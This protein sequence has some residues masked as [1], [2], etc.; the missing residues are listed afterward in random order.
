[1][2]R[3]CPS[4]MLWKTSRKKHTT[5]PSTVL[6]KTS[7]PSLGRSPDP[8]TLPS[9]T[10][11]LPS[12]LWLFFYRQWIWSA[13]KHRL[14]WTSCFSPRYAPLNLKSD[15]FGLPIRAYQGS[16][17]FDYYH[18]EVFERWKPLLS[19]SQTLEVFCSTVRSCW[20]YKKRI[21]VS[22]QLRP[23]T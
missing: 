18:W 23:K 17:L 5:S 1:M 21:R 8:R 6:D 14:D 22:Q 10:E 4:C 9:S 19:A 16:S 7:A 20:T 2:R 12:I 13:T 15:I 11:W 3:S